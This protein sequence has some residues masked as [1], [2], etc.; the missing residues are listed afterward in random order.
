MFDFFYPAL[1]FWGSLILLHE[2]IVDS[3]SLLYS[4]CWMDISSIVCFYSLPMIKIW[5]ISSFGWFWLMLVN[6]RFIYVLWQTYGYISVR[7]VPRSRTTGLLGIYVCST[8]VDTAGFPKWFYQ[9]TL[10]IAMYESSRYSTS[11]ST[12]GI[13]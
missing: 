1:C 8:L 4:F 5:V 11:L 7:C 10:S 2:G 13:L 9:F 3:F 12:L 6:K